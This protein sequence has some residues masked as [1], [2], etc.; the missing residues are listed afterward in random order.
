MVTGGSK[1][2]SWQ[3]SIATALANW[4]TTKSR[5]VFTGPSAAIGACQVPAPYV[6][7]CSAVAINARNRRMSGR[8]RPGSL[9]LP[10]C[11]FVDG[12]VG[13]GRFLSASLGGRLGATMTRYRLAGLAERGMNVCVVYG[14][15][16]STV[17]G[18]ISP[19]GGF[20]GAGIRAR[21]AHTNMLATATP[22]RPLGAWL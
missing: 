14:W 8:P 3:S 5:V 22:G 1:K 12:E 4:T 10:A 15:R 11:G 19:D 20:P 17:T 21:E 7:A 9:R 18:N 6:T 16:S 2:T 13:T